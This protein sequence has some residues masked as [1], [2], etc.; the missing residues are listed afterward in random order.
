[1]NLL[2]HY[3]FSLLLRIVIDMLIGE[4]LITTDMIGVLSTNLYLLFQ[5]KIYL[6]R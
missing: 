2:Y 1:M 3:A 5:S 6:N 4:N